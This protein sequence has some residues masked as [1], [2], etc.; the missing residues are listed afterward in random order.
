MAEKTF[1]IAGTSNANGTVT[2]RVAT[3]R[4]SVREGVL[5]RAGHTD[6]Q[7]RELPNPM[8]RAEAAAWL[9]EQGIS[10]VL[11]VKGG[12]KVLALTA[13]QQRLAH[14]RAEQTQAQLA[15]QE[16][17]DHNYMAQLVGDPTVPVPV[18]IEQAT[19]GP[20]ASDLDINVDELLNVVEGEAG[21]DHER[22]LAKQ[23]T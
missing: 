17:L 18:V 15:R 16:A 20:A 3:G 2:L 4:V 12:G 21:V 23:G 1:T 14:Q 13:E 5:R 10:A 9:A 8:T 6:I 7:L 19:P 22:E 11:P